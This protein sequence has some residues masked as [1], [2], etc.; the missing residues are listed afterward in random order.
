ME[1]IFD[2]LGH[3]LYTNNSHKG[4]LIQW[5]LVSPFTKKWSRNRDPDMG[6]VQ[7]MVEFRKG[8]GYIPRM[9]HLAEITGESGQSEGMVC[10]DGNHRKEVFTI[11]NDDTDPCIIDVMFNATQNDVYQSFCNIN[12]S[13]QLPAIYMDE[14]CGNENTTKFEIIQLVKGYEQ[15]YRPLLS[16]SPRC[17]A[18]HFNRDIFTDNIFQL[19]NSFQRVVSIEQI[20]RLLE[21]LNVEY[22]NGNMGRPHSAYKQ[23]VIEKC[24][25]H[26]MW[27]FV[28]KT[29]PFEHV[30]M[31]V[32]KNLPTVNLEKN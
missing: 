27:L 19:Y 18:P 22:A 21:R 16:T 29:I 30:E 7:E 17:H 14:S 32:A 5:K 26:N 9:I 31:L 6:R 4:Y 8:G 24:A 28:E 20:A 15:K 2:S 3:V 10:Y 23:S 25:K 11:C 12:K 1:T 13:V